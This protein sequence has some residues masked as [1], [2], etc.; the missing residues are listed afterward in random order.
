MKTV[1]FYNLRAGDTAEQP[2]RLTIR[3]GNEVKTLDI[4]P[5]NRMLSLKKPA[6]I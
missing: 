3:E 2:V 5:Q 6:G 4:K 1:D